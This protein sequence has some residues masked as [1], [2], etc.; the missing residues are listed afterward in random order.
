MRFFGMTILLLPAIYMGLIETSVVWCLVFTA[1]Q[2][3][4]FA[5][6]PPMKNT[7]RSY[8]TLSGVA[9]NLFIFLPLVVWAIYPYIALFWL[10]EVAHAVV[11]VIAFLIASWLIP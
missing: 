3:I 6:V 2:L 10:I 5:I 9:Y 8:E 7:V 11:M 4:G 1:W